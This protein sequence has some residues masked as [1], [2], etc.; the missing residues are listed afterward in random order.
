M[1]FKDE[2]KAERG[3]M[4]ADVKRPLLSVSKICEQGNST[5]AI[6]VCYNYEGN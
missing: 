4:I 5:N 2:S 3:F 6:G 1:T